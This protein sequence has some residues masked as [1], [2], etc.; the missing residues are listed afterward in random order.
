MLK[1]FFAPV[2]YISRAFFFVTFSGIF[3]PTIMATGLLFFV[4]NTHAHLYHAIITEP[5]S[6]RQRKQKTEH[7][8]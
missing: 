1:N 7:A 2:F 6:H 5:V 8:K 4:H 3:A